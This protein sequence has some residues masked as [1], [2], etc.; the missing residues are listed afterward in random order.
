VNWVDVLV[1]VANR[2]ALCIGQRFLQLGSEFVDTHVKGSE[3]SFQ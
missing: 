1:V 3:K 2:E